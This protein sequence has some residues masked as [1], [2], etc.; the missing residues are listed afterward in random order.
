MKKE[1]RERELIRLW[2]QRP[3]DKR[4]GNDVLAFYGEIYASHPELLGPPRYGDP[5]QQLQSTLSRHILG[6]R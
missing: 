3:K 6:Q 2:Q 1:D 5:Y 4:T